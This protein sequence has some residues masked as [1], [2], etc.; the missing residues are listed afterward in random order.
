MAEQRFRVNNGLLTDGDVS[1]EGTTEDGFETSLTATDPTADQTIS[2]PDASGGIAV[3]NTAPAS[4]ITD[5]TSGQ[6][7]KTD[8]AGNLSFDSVPAGYT[9]ADVDTHIN[10]STATS[11]QYLGWNGSDYAWSTASDMSW[12]SDWPDDPSSQ[13]IA[14]GGLALGNLT[15]GTYNI[16]IGY[17]AGNTITS[18]SRNIAI[19]RL[20]GYGGTGNYNVNVGFQ[21]GNFNTNGKDYQVNIGYLAGDDQY[22]DETTAIG[23]FAMTDGNHYQSTAVGYRAL[24]NTAT[25]NP[26]YNVG[27]GYSAGDYN[28]FGDGNVYVGYNSD[29]MWNNLSY[30]IAIGHSAYSVGT[31]S[32]SMGYLAGGSAA[33]NAS[34]YTYLFGAY[35]GY[36]L[37]GGDFNCFY[38]YSSGYGGGTSNYNN[39]YGSYSLYNLSSGSY[40]CAFGHQSLYTTS[41]GTGNVGAGYNAGIT[42]QNGSYNV[43]LGYSA[44]T[45]V[46][47]NNYG[48]AIGSGARAD[49]YCVSIGESAGASTLAGSVYNVN[50]GRRAGYDLDGGDFNVFLGYFAGYNGGTGSQNSGVGRE[51]LYYLSTG[52]DNNATGYQALYYVNSGYSN[53]A[54]GVQAGRSVSSG[55][56]N[57]FVGNLAGYKQD[58]IATNGLTTGYNVTCLGNESYPSS[59]TATNEITLG[60]NDITSLRCNVQTISSLSDERDKTA[61]EDLPYGLDFINDMR[62]V[63]FTWNRRDGSLGATPDM[64]FIAQDLYDVELTHS[65]VSRTR[66]VKWD[67]PEKLEADYVRS[68]PILVKAVQELSAK[69]DALEARL[70]ALEGV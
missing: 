50:I 27:V 22:A 14:I 62:P 39:G 70:A 24:G 26:Y 4:A 30:S 23:A 64:G 40:N 9:D 28:Y 60:D 65:S 57:T 58:G 19:G 46:Y 7:L 37:D 41:N 32:A 15:T 55:F 54:L 8:G 31:Y 18:G 17:S 67:N 33:G 21:A 51:A 34:D 44:D 6:F 45:V 48:V 36:D 43:C 29:A 5:G 11:G 52:Y 10:T 12:Q 35:A 25:S 56:N 59:S 69:C 2:L 13:N 16:G 61:I 63:Q 38:G 1:F 53:N 20:S 49:D 68:Y 47:Y 3:F 66:L 42:I